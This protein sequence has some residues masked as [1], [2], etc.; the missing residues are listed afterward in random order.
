MINPGSL[1]LFASHAQA[2][3]IAPLLRDDT[4]KVLAGETRKGY[5]FVAAINRESNSSGR[6]EVSTLVH[7]AR[8]AW[9]AIEDLKPFFVVGMRVELSPACDLWMQG[10]R[11]GT[12]AKIANDW[13]ISVR[14]DHPSVRKL[15]KFSDHTYLRGAL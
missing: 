15:Q 9:I 11:F 4:V 12:I 14:M 5:V 6:F 1:A 10:A 3:Y 8:E 2:K 7:P 13:T